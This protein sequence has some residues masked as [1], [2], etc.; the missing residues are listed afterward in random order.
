MPDQVPENVKNSRCERLLKVCRNSR[1]KI[2]NAFKDEKKRF[3][4]LFEESREGYSYGHTENFIEV[5]VK[6]ELPLDGEIHNVTLV[7]SQE[8]CDAWL[9]NVTD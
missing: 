5:A 4:V 6:S 1:Y 2:I 3:S 9:A 8:G 7:A